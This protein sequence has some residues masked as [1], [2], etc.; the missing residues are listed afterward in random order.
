MVGLPEEVINHYS[1]EDLQALTSTTLQYLAVSDDELIVKSL[2][3]VVAGE[4][5]DTKKKYESKG[6]S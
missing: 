2:I 3:H 4:I 1:E 5:D 6:L